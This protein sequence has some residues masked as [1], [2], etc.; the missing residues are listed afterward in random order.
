MKYNFFFDYIYYRIARAYN[1][2]DDPN[3]IRG[4]V[5][6]AW[7]K[8]VIIGELLLLLEAQFDLL[9]QLSTKQWGYLVLSILIILFTIDLTKY[10]KRY[11]EFHEYWKDEST[12]NRT[13][14]GIYVV[15]CVAFPAIVMLIHGT[16]RHW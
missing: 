15:L 1:K 14:R 2:I 13:I 3:G 4:A 5:I 10:Q 16:I 6:T 11:K 9:K 12:R 8:T 7:I